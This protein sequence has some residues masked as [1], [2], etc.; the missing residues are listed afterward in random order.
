MILESSPGRNNCRTKPG[1]LLGWI[2]VRCSN[3]HN[4]PT[5]WKL[6]RSFPGQLIGHLNVW[7]L[8]WSNFHHHVRKICP[9]ALDLRH[10]IILSKDKYAINVV[11]GPS[12]K[13]R[14]WN[15]GK[16]TKALPNSAITR[17]PLLIICH[18]SKWFFVRSFS[19]ESARWTVWSLTR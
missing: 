2:W 18:R 3:K 11:G 16:F 5:N 19:R 13:E 6:Q 14:L 4:A 12:D 7:R 1:K 15:V 9:E 8:A 17:S 10:E